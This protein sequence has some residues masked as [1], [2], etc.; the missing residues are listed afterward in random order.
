MEEIRAL[1]N[2]YNWLTTPAF[3]KLKS[4][5]VTKLLKQVFDTTDKYNRL[6]TRFAREFDKGPLVHRLLVYTIQIRPDCGEPKDFSYVSIYIELYLY[7]CRID[8]ANYGQL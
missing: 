2:S 4:N 8:G 6:L 1:L 5:D 7:R 3:L